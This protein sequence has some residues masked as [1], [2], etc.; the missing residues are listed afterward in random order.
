MVFL[1]FLLCKI[2]PYCEFLRCLRMSATRNRT[3]MLVCEAFGFAFGEGPVD[4]G[5]FSIT[6]PQCLNAQKMIL[7][8]IYIFIY[9]FKKNMF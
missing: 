2:D 3:D 1:D 9:L 8:Y 6:K 7:I 5:S 4:V